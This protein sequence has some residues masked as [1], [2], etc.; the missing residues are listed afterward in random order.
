MKSNSSFFNFKILQILTGNLH[1]PCFFF[2]QT[3]LKYFNDLTPKQTEQF[4][5][6]QEVYNDWNTKINVISRKDIDALYEKHVLPSRRLPQA[7]TLL[8]SARAADFRVFRWLF[9]F[10]M[11]S[12]IW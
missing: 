1:H 6:L 4:S 5:A 10:P 9:F 11:F 3:I 7:Q 2:M 12:F 8:I